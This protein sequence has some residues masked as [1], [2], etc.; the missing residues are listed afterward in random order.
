V[1]VETNNDTPGAVAR[2]RIFNYDTNQMEDLGTFPLTTGDRIVRFQSI[3]N[4]AAYIR[5]SDGQVR[6]EVRHS[7]LVVFSAQGFQWRTDFVSIAAP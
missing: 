7:A 6:I 1:S 2:I 5:D 3:P 4:H